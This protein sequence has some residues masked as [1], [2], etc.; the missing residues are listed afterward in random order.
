MEDWDDI[1]YFLQVA[2]SGNVTS[3]ASVL[4]VNHSTVSRRVKSLEE[5]HGVQLFERNHTGYKLTDA[6]SAIVELAESM[7]LKSHQLA[8]QLFAHDSRLEGSINLTMPND[9]LDY[10]LM[11][12]I[13]QF[14]KQY[15]EVTLNLEVA[16]G[17]K[18]LAAREA[19]VAV[20][21]TPSP[22]DY[23]IGSQIATIQHGIYVHKNYCA[24]DKVDLIVWQDE[25]EIPL[26]AK[27]HFPDAKIA[28][29]VGDCHSMF[30]AIKMG[31]GVARIPCFLPDIIDDPEVLRLNIDVATSEWG[32]WVLSHVDLRDTLRVKR[33][34]EFLREA[35]IQKKALFQGEKSKYL[36]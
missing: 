31:L 33:C 26:W 6:G 16:K 28:V 13:S 36:Y 12:E 18:N 27:E 30:S 9:L 19:D 15:P 2:K 17:L 35:L 20:R 7:Q 14:K 22:P 29:R 4:G 8:R 10:C 5:K 23:L 11:G 21:L 32:V 3:A 24:G 25:Q 1:R 34:R